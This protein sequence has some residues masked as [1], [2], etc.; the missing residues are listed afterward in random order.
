MHDYSAEQEKNMIE[1]RAELVKALDKALEIFC[2][3]EKK[4]FEETMAYGLRPIA[5]ASGVTRIIIFRHIEING[6]K[7]FRQLYRW[8]KIEGGLTDKSPVF[9][10]VNQITTEWLN[11]LL[12]NICVNQQLSGKSK[13][14][15]TFADMFG[16]KSVFIVPVFSYSALWGG[17]AYL[18]NRSDRLFDEDCMGFMRSAARL[19]ANAVIHNEMEREI[20]EESE[21]ARTVMESS[22][23]SY[24]LFDK[25]LQAI[26]C[27]NIAHQVFN[28]SDKQYLL[29]NF[30]KNFSPV[31]QPDGRKSFEKAHSM[32]DDAFTKRKIVFDWV[33]KTFDDEVLPVENTLTAIVN[34][35]EKYLIC[36]MYD[37]RSIKQMEENIRWLETEAEK[38]YYD[39]LTCIYNRRYFDENL[40]RILKLLSRT[41]S[42]IS[43]MMID[44]DF[45]KKYND[46]YG[47]SEGDV[48]L[49]AVANTLS[50]TLTRGDD[51]VAR[52]GGE[53]FAVVLPN[54]DEAGARFLAGKLLENIQNCKIL[55]ENSDIADHVTISIGIT[56]GKTDYTRNPDDYIKRADEMLYASKQ[57][58]RNR[59][60]FGAM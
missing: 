48:C 36:Y 7:C 14:D 20:A 6:E 23:V 55:H 2:S 1:R 50:K 59:Y 12:E 58:G 60:T 10:P 4:T 15:K 38:V 46:T 9:F 52:Y 30:W 19:C 22:P 26:D 37:L 34:N 40:S 3:H 32:K 39:A 47:H 41:E 29:H 56:T 21:I 18:D 27:N 45:F 53:E 24:I 5:D 44:I 54:T 28:C 35:N 42:T 11:I 51:F 16:K 43:L 13:D 31:Y 17:V 25:D 57:N 49:K 33:H 8:D